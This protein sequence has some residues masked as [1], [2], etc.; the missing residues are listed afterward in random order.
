MEKE[1]IIDDIHIVI[2]TDGEDGYT[3]FVE[4]DEIYRLVDEEMAEAIREW[5]LVWLD[6]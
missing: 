3:V 4:K 6:N 5:V 2:Y 1:L